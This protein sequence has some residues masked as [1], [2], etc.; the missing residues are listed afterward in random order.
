MALSEP[1]HV[2]KKGEATLPLVHPTKAVEAVLEPNGFRRTFLREM[3][4]WQVTLY[5]RA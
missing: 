3:G 1:L 2:Q 5:V 4:A